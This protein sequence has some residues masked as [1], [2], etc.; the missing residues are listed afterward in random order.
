MPVVVDWMCSWGL[1]GAGAEFLKLGL[2]FVV[3]AVCVG[4]GRI[5]DVIL[6]M[7]ENTPRL[8]VIQGSSTHF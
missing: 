3:E 7:G 2:G 1:D 8:L 5:V 4:Y 6:Q